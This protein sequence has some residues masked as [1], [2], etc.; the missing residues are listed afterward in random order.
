VPKTPAELANHEAIVYMQEGNG[1]WSCRRDTAEVS[2]T[3]PARINVSAAEGVRAAVLSDMGIAITSSWVFGPELTS[4]AVRRVLA[5]WGLPSID[6]RAVYPTG[7]MPSAKARAF[8][9]FVE[10]GTRG[11]PY[12]ACELWRRSPAAWGVI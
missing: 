6:L 8:A 2:V 4:G 1:A 3:V 12:S 10:K 9:A 5:D 11:G 7:R